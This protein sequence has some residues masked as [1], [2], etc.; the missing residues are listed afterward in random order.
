MKICASCKEN[1]PFD[2]FNKCSRTT[3]N[4]QSYCRKCQSDK[5]RQRRKESGKEIDK[6]TWQKRKADPAHFEKRKKANK[7]WRENNPEKYKEIWKRT[8]RQYKEKVLLKISDN[9]SCNK[10][11]CDKRELL[12]INHINGGG[13]KEMRKLGNN[14]VFYK[15]I[16]DGTRSAT[17]LEILCKPCNI[18]HYLEM[19]FGKLP[20]KL[21]WER[22]DE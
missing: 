9:L 12:E 6:K 21:T 3:D 8:N 15:S 18:L 7:K 17:D 14:K 5:L 22:T 2:C 10:C 13:S 1:L 11:G 4:K 19:K 16:L 20:Y